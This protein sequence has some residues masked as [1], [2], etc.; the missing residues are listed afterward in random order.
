MAINS[1]LVVA[2]LGYATTPPARI[3]VLVIALSF[4]FV[5][6]VQLQKHRFFQEARLDDFNRVQEKLKREYADMLEI[7]FGTDDIIRLRSDDKSM[8][9]TVKVSWIRKRI[10][11]DWLTRLQYLSLIAI[12]TFLAIEILLGF[13]SVWTA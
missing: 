13:Y 12:A 11:F 1:F 10:A 7:V 5:S 8:Y 6:T 3:F 2:Y 4:T 9:Q